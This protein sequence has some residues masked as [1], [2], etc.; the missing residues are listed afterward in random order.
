M[1]NTN[2]EASYYETDCNSASFRH[3]YYS[4][5][6]DKKLREL[7]SL[8]ITDVLITNC[9]IFMYDIINHWKCVINRFCN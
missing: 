6:V 3:L 5:F 1:F 2:L 7:S 9:N 4:A 8:S